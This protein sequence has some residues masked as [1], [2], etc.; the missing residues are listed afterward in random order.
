MGLMVYTHRLVDPLRHGFRYHRYLQ[1]EGDLSIAGMYIRSREHLTR[2]SPSSI[3]FRFFHQLSNKEKFT[4]SVSLS[5]PPR[6]TWLWCT[7]AQSATTSNLSE[8]SPG[9]QVVVGLACMLT[10][11]EIERPP[12]QLHDLLHLFRNQRLKL[13]LE[14]RP[15]AVLIKLVKRVSYSPPHCDRK[16]SLKNLSGNQVVVCVCGGG[17]ADVPTF[18][19]VSL[20]DVLP[21]DSELLLHHAHEPPSAVRNGSNVLC[22]GLCGGQCLRR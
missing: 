8:R 6:D 1:A 15:I 3:P 10:L 5:E 20:L 7:S 11:L 12:K 13:I 2:T 4:G 18:P 9:N 14:D 21:P 16:Q 17:G 22:D 19:P